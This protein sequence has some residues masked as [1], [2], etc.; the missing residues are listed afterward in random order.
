MGPVESQEATYHVHELESGL[1]VLA[2]NPETTLQVWS[3]DYGYPGE[4]LYREFHRKDPLSGLH[5]WRVTHRKADLA[6]K[7]PYDPEAAFA[8]TEEHAR[9]FVGLLERL[10][11]R[12]P[13]GVILS[14]YDAE[15]F[16]HWW[17]EGWPEPGRPEA[18]RPEPQG[19]A[20]DRPGGGAGPRGADRPP[21]GLLGPGRG[22]PGLA[23]REDPGLLGKGLSGGGGHAGGG[24]PGCPPRGGVAPGHARAFAPR[25]S[26]WPFLMETGQAEAYARERYEEHAR[27]FFHLLKG[28][29]PRSLGPWRSGTIPSRRPTPA[30]TFSGRRDGRGAPRRPPVPPREEPA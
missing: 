2:R 1:R 17:Y 12:H 11:G 7:A 15:L 22:P 9:H 10:A 20:R 14:P 26:D 3:A 29:S 4:G 23:Q 30:S 27:A 18:S 16:G 5:H 6:E 28:A 19:P 25:A 24:A 13:E 8:K 21:R